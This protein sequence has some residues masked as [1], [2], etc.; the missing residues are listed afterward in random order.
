MREE[1]LEEILGTS[2]INIGLLRLA[3]SP[4]SAYN[5]NGFQRL[6]FLGDSILGM[7]V[8]EYLFKNYCSQPAGW[9]TKVRSH[10]VRNEMLGNIGTKLG[11]HDFINPPS[12]GSMKLSSP[13]VIASVVEAIIAAVYLD[14]GFEE[15]TRI[16]YGTVLGYLDEAV[17]ETQSPKTALQNKIQKLF[18]VLPTYGIQER[19]DG[20]VHVEIYFGSV[21]LG[22]GQA[23][24]K[25][26]AEENAA[27]DALGARLWES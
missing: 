13:R 4:S 17:G 5:N 24:N 19:S 18:G 1:E 15:A 14:Q 12:I 3:L 23:S 7:I 27:R 6:E 25:K 11:L 21:M 16:V 26:Q 20:N 10:L 8:A 22:S 2:F 9:M